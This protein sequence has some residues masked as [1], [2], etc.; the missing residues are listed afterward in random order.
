[1][2]SVKSS[3]LM[4]C[5]SIRVRGCPVASCRWAL[6]TLKGRVK[7][8]C[9]RD[10]CICGRVPRDKRFVLRDALPRP[11]RPTPHTS[12][13]CKRGEWGRTSTV[14]NSEPRSL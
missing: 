2:P 14:I 7:T 9:G 8:R 5:V 1:M 12:P 6:C 4:G 10:R 13:K 11:P 3:L